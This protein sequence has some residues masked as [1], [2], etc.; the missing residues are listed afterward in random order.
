M[1]REDRK[2]LVG[3]GVPPELLKFFL[4]VAKLEWH[5]SGDLWGELYSATQ[6]RPREKISAATVRLLSTAK[7]GEV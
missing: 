4:H 5:S 1:G 3:E 6:R 7:S 2:L